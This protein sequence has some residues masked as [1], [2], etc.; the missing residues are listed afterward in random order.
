MQRLLSIYRPGEPIEH[1]EVEYNGSMATFST[2]EIKPIFGEDVDVTSEE[3]ADCDGWPAR[4]FYPKGD[5]EIWTTG[6]Y[7]IVTDL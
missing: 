1:K 3:S 4:A 7:V 2:T 5:E 6:T